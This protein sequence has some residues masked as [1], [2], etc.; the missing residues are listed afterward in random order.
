MVRF[1]FGSSGTGKS[2][3]VF[4][5]IE[6]TLA[7]NSRSVCLI[8]PEQH[9]VAVERRAAE[10][11]PASSVLRLEVTNFTRLSDSISRRVGALS[12]NKLTRGAKQL[13]VWRALMSVYEGL[14]E[15]G[16]A[17]GDAVSLVPTVYSALREL[18]LGGVSPRELSEAAD[19]LEK[20]EGESSLSRRAHDLSLIAAAYSE[21][22]DSE[23]ASLEDPVLRVRDRAA[24]SG[25]FDNCEVFI[26]SFY[27]MTGA[28]LAALGEIIR[29]AAD[30]TLTIP[31]ESADADGVHLSGVRRFYKSVL[32]AALKRGEIERVTLH[33]NHR[34]KSESLLRLNAH[35]WDYTFEM[36]PCEN[37]GAVSVYS[38]ADRY[39]EAEALSSEIARLVREGAKYSDIAVVAADVERLR[40]ITDAA[41]RSHNIP[42]F[43]S[44]TRQVSASPAVRLIFSLL[45]VVGR[46]RREDVISIVKTG[47]SSLDDTSACAF[48]NYT[49]TWNIRTRAMF[50]SV[51]NM[52]PDGYVEK[53]SE[54][55]RETLCLANEAR[56]VLVAPL[57]RFCTVFDDGRAKIS[58][59][60]AALT[61]YFDESGAYFK[62]LERAEALPADDAARERLVWGEICSAFDTLV[63]I[64]GDATCDSS[65]FAALF[66]FVISDSD[67]GAIPTG[68]DNVTFAS[69]SGLRSDGVKHVFIL[70]AVDGEFPVVPSSDGYFSD[71]DR[72]R[73]AENGIVLGASG[74]VRASEELFRFYRAVSQASQSLCVFIPKSTAGSS[75]R[76]SE[77][78]QRIMKLSGAQ[79]IRYVSTAASRRVFDKLSLDSELRRTRDS[80]L[81]ELRVSLYGEMPKLCETVTEDTHVDAETARMLF[82]NR[83]NL[84]QSRIERFVSCP[85][86]YYCTYILDLE[87]DKKASV[88]SPDIGRFVHAVLEQ[89][90]TVTSGEKYPLSRE[91]TDSLCESITEDYIR[92]T[93]GED[94]DGRLKYL[95]VR[96]RRKLSVFLEAIMEEMAQSRFEIYRTEL[97]VGGVRGEEDV[98]AP[99]AINFECADGGTVS[100]Y[101]IIDRL[102]IYKTEGKTYIRVIDYKT[103]KRRFSYENV[104]LGL[105]VQLL[106]YLFCA[107]KSENTKFARE[108]SSGEI[109]PAGAMY[110]SIRPDDPS[111]PSPVNS[112]EARELMAKSIERSGVVCDERDVLDAMDSG[113]TGKYTPVTL[114]ADGSYKQCASLASLE[115]FGELYR[116]LG[117][118]VCRIADEMKSGL[119][120]PRPIDNAAVDPCAFCSAGEICRR[121]RSAR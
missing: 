5:M 39:E 113:I 99:K 51:W 78:A 92:R 28:Q 18:T 29:L 110:L 74:D 47:L 82:G 2:T 81:E 106:L 32:G 25:Y 66:K 67:T 36:P 59:I 115:R 37:D 63:E 55:A 121:R 76:P 70:G 112:D 1:I 107:W 118:T 108:I 87:E 38:V 91:R 71:N 65:G 100:L 89:F 31:M 120:A 8:V 104:K 21:L 102:D 64:A 30:V 24:E 56:E 111:A 84:T 69:A 10:R 79:E 98:A 13:L 50:T 62:M 80:S 15:L 109:L 35:L 96:L 52:N 6:K 48:E 49:E 40:G 45:R 68:V 93:F 94:V 53:M 41:L 85:M 43:I 101:G 88:A 22:S 97:P 33:D 95:F 116:E 11:F 105:D 103:G 14:E 57:E 26:D 54:R 77:G 16:S 117:D 9:T 4:D 7:E 44:E 114:K 90:F 19:S 34:T 58:D 12:Y 61:E 20:L 72:E 17:G 73:L 23:Y 42:V 27:S 119:A 83:L 86:S 3:L 46:W 60:C 75:C